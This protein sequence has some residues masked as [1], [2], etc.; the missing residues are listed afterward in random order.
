MARDF[1]PACRSSHLTGSGEVAAVAEMA[2]MCVVSWT[3]ITMSVELLNAD[4]TPQEDALNCALHAARSL[5]TMRS[6]S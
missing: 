5:A 6:G 3:L 1:E 4:T 2:R